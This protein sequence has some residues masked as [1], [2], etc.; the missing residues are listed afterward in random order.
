MHEDLS[1]NKAFSK[2]YFYYLTLFKLEFTFFYIKN[3][4]LKLN[5][6]RISLGYFNSLKE[7][8]IVREIFAEKQQGEFYSNINRLRYRERYGNDIEDEELFINRFKT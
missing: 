3:R 8:V 6:K 1:T 4:S 2:W 7:A 5:K